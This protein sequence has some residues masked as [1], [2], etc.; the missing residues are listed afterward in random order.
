VKRKD[1]DKEVFI[2]GIKMDDDKNVVKR[3]AHNKRNEQ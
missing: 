1:S 2:K 3:I